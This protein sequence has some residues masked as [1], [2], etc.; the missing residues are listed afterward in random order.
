[1]KKIWDSVIYILAVLWSIPLI[2]TVFTAFKLKENALKFNIGRL[3]LQ[4]YKT[5]FDTAPFGQY[6]INTV[7]IVLGI[8]AVQFITA[9]C[10]AYAFARLRFIGREFLF[11][12]ILVQIIIPNDILIVSNYST[13]SNLS[14]I[15]TKLG[16]MVPFFGTA[17][18]IFLMRQ[19]FKTIPPDIEEASKIDGCGILRI[20]KNIY[21]PLGKPAYISF[22]LVSISYHW[23]DFLWPLIVTSSVENR[24]LT[25]GLAMFA[26]TF[27]TGAQWAEVTAATCLVIFPLILMFFIFQKQFI[28]SFMHSGIK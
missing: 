12:L 15:N 9:T 18:G 14:L 5:I 7:V 27:E 11:M 26:K 1:M 21:I 6:F 16:I 8:L 4:N 24:P 28:K 2:W 23:N 13:L 20:I 17:F 22:S 10:S 25:V 3:T 19:T